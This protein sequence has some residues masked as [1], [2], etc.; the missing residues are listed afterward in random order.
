MQTLDLTTS[1]WTVRAHGD[2]SGDAGVPEAVR[3]RVFPARIPGC[4]HTDLMRA[5]AIPDPR[6]GFNER[7]Q[8]WI[9]QTDW[10]YECSFDLTP[11]LLN[12]ERIDLACD[13]LDT[14]AELSLNDQP[15]GSAVNQFHPHRFNLRAAAKP[16]PNT[17]RILFRSPIKHIFAEQKRLGARPV[18]G[19]WDPYIFIRKAACNFGWDW[20]PKVATCGIWKPLRIEAWSKAR[21]ASIRALTHRRPESSLWHVDVHIEI[22]RSGASRTDDMFACIGFVNEEGKGQ[23]D[24]GTIADDRSSITLKLEVERPR[25]WTPRDANTTSD[26]PFYTLDVAIADQS[27][28]DMRLLALY[29]REIRLN[30]DPDQHGNKFQLEVNG[31]PVFC[32]GANWIPEGLFPDDRS[33]EKIRERVRQAAAANMNM[34]RVWGGG[35]YESDEFYDECDRLGIM[36]WQDFMFA[37]ACYPEEE[38]LR[39]LVET[40]ARHQIARLSAHPSVVLWCGGNECIWGY[41]SW[42]HAA[43]DTEGPWKKRIGS[44]TWGRGYYFDLLPHLMRELD[45][46]RPY[47]P[48][49]P[50]SGAEGENP[51]QTNRGDRHTWDASPGSRG[52]REITPRFCAEFGHQA[53]ANIETLRAVMGPSDFAVGSA[54]LQHRQRASGGMERHVDEPMRAALAHHPDLAARHDAGT[55]EGWHVLAQMTQAG[56]LSAAIEHLAA[57]RPHCM[58]ALIWQFNDAWPS[59]S[60]SL[61]DSDGKPKPAFFAVQKAFARITPS[62]PASP[63]PRSTPAARTETPSSPERSP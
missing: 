34:L 4:I 37:C 6:I 27:L 50:F 45:P 58:G 2:E 52:F 53:P 57:N 59:L 48:N 3:G 28:L 44:R 32:K 60:W 14:I 19:D 8:Q 62:T 51:N 63:P 31:T 54:A 40:E 15:I 29:F 41:E 18:N 22:E 23:G 61:I 25:L 24:S 10:L 47:W 13:G 5:G 20:A 46:T 43:T 49:S 9:G 35:F 39:S 33:P 7:D 11:D 1:A 17:L 36:V 26:Q 38:P 16:G 55:F 30:T 21:L 42:G 56:S 12:H